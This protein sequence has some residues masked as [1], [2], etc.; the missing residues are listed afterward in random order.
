MIF[1]ER[2]ASTINSFFATVNDKERTKE[3]NKESQ[4]L[5]TCPVSYYCPPFVHPRQ[6]KSTLSFDNSPLKV[7][8]LDHWKMRFVAKVT[9]LGVL[10]LC[11]VLWTLQRLRASGAVLLLEEN[12]KHTYETAETFEKR[13]VVFGDSWSGSVSQQEQQGDAWTQWFCLMVKRSLT[14]FC[15]RSQ[16]NRLQYSCHVENFAQAARFSGGTYAGSVINNDELQR[17]QPSPNMP[18][19][20]LPDLKTQIDQWISSERGASNGMLYDEARQTR[21]AN[22]IFVVSF[23]VWDLWKLRDKPVDQAKDSIHHSIDSLFAG[24]DSL[25]EALR[26]NDLK[27]ILLMSL[28][29]TFL[30]AFNSTLSKGGSQKDMV[31]LVDGWNKELRNKAKD[32]DHGSIYLFDTNSFMLDQIRAWQ[33]FAAGMNDARGLGKNEDPGWEDVQHP[34]IRKL[35][36]WMSGRKDSTENPCGRPEK[37]LFW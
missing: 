35:E 29:V 6:T 2:S 36:S 9:L 17:V 32:W 5:R 4:S 22:T 26:S 27:I 25:S 31:T 1:P 16:L 28:D 37:Y 15:E 21:A 12:S 11:S 13:L 14:I 18:Q 24:L 30:P 10:A 7:D 19:K 33:F 8:V 34:C 3:G 20:P 23:V